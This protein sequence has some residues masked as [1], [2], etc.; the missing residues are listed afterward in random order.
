MTGRPAIRSDEPHAALAGAMLLAGQA[1]GR[2]DDPR[3]EAVARRRDEVVFEPRPEAT[4][5][6][7]EGAA[8]YRELVDRVLGSADR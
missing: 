8:R 1:L 3:A 5:A 6:Y 4:A 2:W 7:A